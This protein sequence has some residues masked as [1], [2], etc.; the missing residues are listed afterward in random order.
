MAPD[1]GW[2]WVICV[3]AGLN[4][5]SATIIDH[6]GVSLTSHSFLSLSLSLSLFRFAF[7]Q[8]FMFP[9]LQQ[10][11]LIYKERMESLGF[12]KKDT[13]IIV[14]VVMTLSSLVGKSIG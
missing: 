6:I 8:F 5:V 11:G 13:T 2:G 3:A 10:F 7:L 14:N 12:D 1:G 9:P 4:N